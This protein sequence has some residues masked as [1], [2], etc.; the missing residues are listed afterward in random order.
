MNPS[1]SARA[2]QGICSGVAALLVLS[3]VPAFGSIIT[4]VNTG[5]SGPGSLRDAIASAAPGDTIDFSLA[6]PATIRLLTPLT[7]GPS[8]TMTIS[9]PGASNLTISGEDNVVVF[10]VNAGAE[11]TISGLTITRG[12]SLLG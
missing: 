10:V 7:L 5:D 8:P 3:A 12:S 9:G 6:Y 1:P 2:F 4:V 11:D